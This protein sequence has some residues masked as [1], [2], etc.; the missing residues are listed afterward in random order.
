MAAV[1]VTATKTFSILSFARASVQN[2]EA[3]F[4][5]TGLAIHLLTAHKNF[6]CDFN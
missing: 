3:L 1:A 5:F 6:I 4:F 2:T